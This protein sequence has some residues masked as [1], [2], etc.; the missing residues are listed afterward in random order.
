ML[1]GDPEDKK[2][3]LLFQKDEPGLIFVQLGGG[4]SAYRSTFK[5]RHNDSR[6]E[7]NRNFVLYT[8]RRRKL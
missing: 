2:A 8:S 4:D 1:I 6:Y 3:G 7:Y 5:C